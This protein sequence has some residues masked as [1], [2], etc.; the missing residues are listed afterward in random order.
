VANNSGGYRENEGTALEIEGKIKA[1]K[2][3]EL[4]SV[5]SITAALKNVNDAQKGIKEVGQTFTSRRSALTD[6]VNR[7]SASVGAIDDLVRQ[8]FQNV[9]A[10][11]RLPDVSMQG[12]P[13]FSW[14]KIS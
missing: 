2:V 1:I 13:N 12:L 8:D 4:K 10:L 7:L 5:E 11:A 9:L 14:E 3:N 6:E